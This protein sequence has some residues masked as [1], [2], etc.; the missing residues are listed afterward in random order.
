MFASGQRTSRV[1]KRLG[2]L[3]GA[4]G[5]GRGMGRGCGQCHSGVCRSP[6][7]P[8]F[9][10]LQLLR[11]LWG[12]DMWLCAVADCCPSL[13]CMVTFSPVAIS[14][15]APGTAIESEKFHALPSYTPPFL[16]IPSCLFSREFEELSCAST[17]SHVGALTGS[18]VSCKYI[19]S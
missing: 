6:S 16:T 4:Q 2:M 8:V 13:L 9:S 11:G 17:Q 1:M 7:A 3:G 18:Y 12:P 14:L 19:F 5:C 10:L 15:P